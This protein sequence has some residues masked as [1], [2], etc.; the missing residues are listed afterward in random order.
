MWVFVVCCTF[1]PCPAEMHTAD[2]RRDELVRRCETR[3]V[4]TYLRQRRQYGDV[5]FFKQPATLLCWWMCIWWWWTWSNSS[6]QSQM[7]LFKCES[8][9]LPVQTCQIWFHLFQA[10]SSTSNSQT[11]SQTN[12]TQL[13]MHICFVGL[14]AFD[15]LEWNAEINL[16][17]IWI[18][19]QRE[20][21]LL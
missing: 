21:A 5:V 18:F 3:L 13:M 15:K 16:P 2:R 7:C 17:S 14:Q 1:S 6:N 12:K 9:G 19:P 8:T 20:Y 10:E 11:C 4:D